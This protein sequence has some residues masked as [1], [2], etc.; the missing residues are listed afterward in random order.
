MTKATRKMPTYEEFIEFAGE[1]LYHELMGGG[2]G[3]STL[4]DMTAETVVKFMFG[5]VPSAKAVR[6]AADKHFAAAKR[7]STK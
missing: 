3:W 2:S 4:G 6:K 5:K 7:Y 1:H